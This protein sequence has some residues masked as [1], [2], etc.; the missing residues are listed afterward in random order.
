[1]DDGKRAFSAIEV[2][3]EWRQPKRGGGEGGGEWTEAR[4]GR[5]DGKRALARLKLVQAPWVHIRGE[6]EGGGPKTG[7]RGADLHASR[8]PFSSFGREI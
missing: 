1:M 8:F 4:G 7:K 2:A 3:F 6:C 5:D